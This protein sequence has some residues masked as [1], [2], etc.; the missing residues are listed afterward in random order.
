ML[1]TPCRALAFRGERLRRRAEDR[2][3]KRAAKRTKLGK[4]PLLAKKEF[5][6]HEGRVTKHVNKRRLE[7]ER[8]HVFITLKTL[9]LYV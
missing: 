5:T 3:M 9:W 8:T 4:K 6:G 2:A 1:T 7:V